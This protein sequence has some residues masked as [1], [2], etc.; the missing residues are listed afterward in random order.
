MADTVETNVVFNGTRH[1]VV[2]ITNESDGT[3]E[4]AVSK[5]DISTLTGPDGSAPTKTSVMEI[6]YAVSG[7]NYIVLAWDHT[8]NDTIAV[9]KG[10]GILDFEADGGLVDPASA[11]GTGDIV[12]TT[13]GAI[14]NASYDI[15]IKIRLKD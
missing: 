13:D 2:H 11:G 7:F 10:Q 12:L 5:I 6:E 8:A 4:A 3:G 15:R 9:L 14:N 1:Y